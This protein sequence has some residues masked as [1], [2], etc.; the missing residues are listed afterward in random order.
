MDVTAKLHVDYSNYTSIL[1]IEYPKLHI[2]FALVFGLVLY[3]TTLEYCFN[4]LKRSFAFNI[5]KT[6]GNFSYHHSRIHQRTKYGNNVC[7][8]NYMCYSI[9]Q[10]QFAS[11]TDR[12]HKDGFSSISSSDMIE[13]RSKYKVWT[14]PQVLEPWVVFPVCTCCC[15]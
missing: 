10:P 6:M 13:H 9:A 1:H 14:S 2:D 11:Y 3:I 8:R 4:G 12:N 7:Q 15:F 5:S